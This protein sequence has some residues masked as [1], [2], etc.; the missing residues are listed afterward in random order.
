MVPRQRLGDIDAHCRDRRNA[1]YG[2]RPGD[3][4]EPAQST[5]A[6]HGRRMTALGRGGMS[7]GCHTGQGTDGA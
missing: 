1:G 2:D 5:I 3:G 4:G 7:D 6:A